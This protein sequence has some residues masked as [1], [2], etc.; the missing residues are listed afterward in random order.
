MLDVAGGENVF[1]DVRTQSVQ[2]STEM[3]L[4]RRPEVII[5]LRYGNSQRALEAQR[6]LSVWDALPSVRNRQ[7]HILVGDQFVIPGPRVVEAARQ[8]ART[9]H[10]NVIR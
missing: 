8:L 9:L 4:A 10:P 6:E 5:E 1:A 3:I 2:A 7:V